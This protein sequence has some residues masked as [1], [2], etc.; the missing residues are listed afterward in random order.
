MTGTQ[1]PTGASEPT[2]NRRVIRLPRVLPLATRLLAAWLVC[3]A[4]A[5]AVV[6]FSPLGIEY[7]PYARCVTPGHPD[8]SNCFQYVITIRAGSDALL[9]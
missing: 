2:D 7:A 9:S 4:V 3:G 5:F 6:W 1:G 8:L